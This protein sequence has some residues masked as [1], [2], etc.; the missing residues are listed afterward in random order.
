MCV[1]VFLTVRHLAIILLTGAVYLGARGEGSVPKCHSQQIQ[2]HLNVL[3]YSQISLRYLDVSNTICLGD[4]VITVNLS[5]GIQKSRQLPNSNVVPHLMVKWV[6]QTTTRDQ[7][8]VAIHRVQ[9]QVV[10]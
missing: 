3:F 5:A 7:R 9:S 4:V 2:V 6:R 8:T 10:T 1:C